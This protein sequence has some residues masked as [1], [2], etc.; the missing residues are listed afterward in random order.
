MAMND[1]GIP[2]T[3]EDRVELAREVLRKCITAGIAR[4]DVILDPLALAV[5]DDPRA[6]LTTLE[7]INQ[8][9]RIEAVNLTLRPDRICGGL[10]RPRTIEDLFVALAI[11]HGVTCPI[12]DPSKGRQAVLIADVLLGRDDSMGRYVDL[13]K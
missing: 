10:P 12:I 7:T 9:A 4:S 13:A 3:V 6:A 11:R 8:L 5:D 2:R 1:H